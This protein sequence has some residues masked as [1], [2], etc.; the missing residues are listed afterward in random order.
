MQISLHAGK[1]LPVAV[2][3]VLVLFTT[4]K[5]AFTPIVLH[6]DFLSTG[7]AFSDKALIV[8]HLKPWINGGSSH[9]YAKDLNENGP[10]YLLFILA[11]SNKMP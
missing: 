2:S 8:T 7:E 5:P 6:D 4:K 1:I 10:L 11:T 3:G 9:R